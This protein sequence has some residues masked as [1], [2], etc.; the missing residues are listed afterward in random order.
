MDQY[1]LVNGAR[2]RWSTEDGGSPGAD[3]P[4]SEIS[5]PCVPII[6][7]GIPID[8]T[9]PSGTI[10]MATTP[11]TGNTATHTTGTAC[12]I[13]TRGTSQKFVLEPTNNQMSFLQILKTSAVVASP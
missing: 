5:Y 6:S 10:I 11:Q 3:D 1:D 12:G 8:P 7:T 13:D 2:W 9:N 4:S